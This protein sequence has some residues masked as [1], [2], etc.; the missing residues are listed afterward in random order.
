MGF[1]NVV[2]SMNRGPMIDR[3]TGNMGIDRVCGLGPKD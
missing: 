2:G 3:K 1:K